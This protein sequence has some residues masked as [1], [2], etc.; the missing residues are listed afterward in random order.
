MGEGGFTPILV[1]GAALLALWCDIRFPERRAPLGRALLHLGGAC[2]VLF[3]MPAVAWAVGQAGNT[4]AL[5]LAVVLG[6]VLP[7]LTY[8]LLVGLWLVRGAV[9]AT[10]G[11]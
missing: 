3:A 11:R 4:P 9:A 6:V 8:A 5:R 1:A 7:A 10:T 2:L